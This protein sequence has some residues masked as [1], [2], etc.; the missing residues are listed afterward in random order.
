MAAQTL[1]ATSNFDG[2]SL[3]LGL[4]N[5]EAITVNGGA[6][7]IDSDV[8]W[9]QNAAVL[10]SIT[11][12]ATLG[13]SVLFD[14]RNVWELPYNAAT[15]NVPAQNALGSN[16]VTGGTS[17]ATGELLRVWAAGSL[18][19]SAAGGAMP[20][21]GWVK[22]RSKTGTFQAGE[23]VTLPGGAT[24]TISGSGKR[25][26][27]HI[28]GAESGTLTWG[29]LADVKFR[30]EWY[31]LGATN[32]ADDQT[33]QFP[34]ADACPAIWVEK[35]AGSYAL[36]G[37]F[38]L[39][40]WLSAGGRWGTVTQFVSTD[41][42]GKYFGQNLATGVI[43]IAQRASNA[44]GYK[45]AAGLK[46]FVP[47]LI[48]SSSTSANWSSNTINATM[49]TRY[50][51]ATTAGGTVDVVGVSCN[52][53]INATTPV[54]YSL[55][56]SGIL[57]Q[58]LVSGVAKSVLVE[59]VG[60]GVNSGTA[61]A[62]SGLSLVSLY[63]SPVLRRV[64]STKAVQGSSISMSDV[65]GLRGYTI[66]AE[67]FGASGAVNRSATSIVSMDLTRCEDTIFSELVSIGARVR[68]VA[69]LD[70]EIHG[71]QY[72]D[73][74]V[75]E[76]QTGANMP[77]AVE[78]SGGSGRCDVYGFENFGGLANVHPG[79]R[80][81]YAANASAVGLY[82]VGS[83]SSPYDLGT[84]NPANGPV[85]A[86]VLRGLT[87]RR[88]YTR[89]GSTPGTTSA[90]QL[91]STVQ[92][93]DLV[94]VWGD[95]G[96]NGAFS[97]VNVTAKGCKWTPTTIG[98]SASYGTHW[99]DTYT[100]DTTGLVVIH[101]NEPTDATVGQCSTSFAPGSGFTS[102]GGV[103]MATVG[104]F[105]EWTMPYFALGHTALANSAPTV[106]GANVGNHTLEFQA[107]TGSGWS[108]WAALT[109]A[110]LEAVGAINP[111]TGVR[112]RVRA[113]VAV[114]SAANLLTYIRIDTVTDAVS[115]QIQYPVTAAYTLTLDNVAVGSLVHVETAAG[116]AV[117]SVTAVASTVVLPLQ[118]YESGSPLN[119]LRVKV[120][121]G[122]AAP[123]YQPW[124]TL[125][126]AA[127]GS[128][129]IYVSQIPDE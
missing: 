121:K 29:R 115:Q 95:G 96:N 50:E 6:L 16:G 126:T 113:T 25:S 82:D 108:A 13:G 117:Y 120:R 86:L 1:T 35:Y 85:N 45:P 47:N 33:F 87:V 51:T 66:Q 90:V 104:D 62:Y 3:M 31:E 9:N 19:P 93:V 99:S 68:F 18:T 98:Q 41:V 100:S 63:G 69:C 12:S 40:P 10:G 8:R 101:C 80:I 81:L 109:G 57:E 59:D 102:A 49:A 125:A 110:N 60:L 28:V 84:V 38:G 106:T 70:S 46:V 105:V 34:V 83:P 20:A 119:N 48:L 42:R 124:E 107:D 54:S 79:T 56:R 74:L 71:F 94:N 129:S 122:S 52:W 112:L 76:T 5:G 37:E 22:L 114:A 128:A 97:A 88:V 78:A 118:A 67:T 103:S 32:G 17:G 61:T 36:L 7:T 23:V 127:P 65:S 91:A 89:N 77:G 123:F 39:E 2:P 53:Y 75:G 4:N 55:Q 72:A 58:A 44:C 116:A 64:R 30:G 27:L 111:A 21:T 73:N 15:G 26:W 92:D 11:V 24:I 14:G 43:T